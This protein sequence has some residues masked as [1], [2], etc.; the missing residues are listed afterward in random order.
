IKHFDDPALSALRQLDDISQMF[1]P[2]QKAHFLSQTFVAA[3]PVIPENIWFSRVLP[4]FNEQL[5]DSHELF[6][7]LSKPLFF[8]LDHCE[9]HN[10]HKLRTW[11]RK[12]LDHTSQKPVSQPTELNFLNHILYI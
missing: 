12:I 2:S 9:S 5:F 3:L 11:M 10:I 4:R 7:A 6:P 8:M 1:D